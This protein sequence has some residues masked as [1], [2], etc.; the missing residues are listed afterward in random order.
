MDRGEVVNEAV[1]FVK[2]EY[3][4]IF[5]LRNIL[6][7][8]DVYCLGPFSLSPMGFLYLVALPDD[9]FNLEH[10]YTLTRS[11]IQWERKVLN[12]MFTTTQKPPSRGD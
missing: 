1:K 9:S 4:F 6:R 11:T 5:S 3:F 2:Y 12:S 7:A 10:T 8:F